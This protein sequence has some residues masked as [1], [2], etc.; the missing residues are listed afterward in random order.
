MNV[1]RTP[2]ASTTTGGDRDSQDAGIDQTHE[3]TTFMEPDAGQDIHRDGQHDCWYTD[4]LGRYHGTD[5]PGFYPRHPPG[6]WRCIRP[7]TKAL[8]DGVCSGN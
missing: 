4:G 2:S 6:D 5:D 1:Q 7:S 3:R 8:R